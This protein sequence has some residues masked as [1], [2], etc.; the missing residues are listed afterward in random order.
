GKIYSCL[1]TYPYGSPRRVVSP[2]LSPTQTSLR[3][4]YI[5]T[6]LGTSLTLKEAS[7][8][9]ERAGYGVRRAT[10][11]T[12]QLEIPGYRT[13]IMHSVDII[14]VIALAMDIN[15]LKPEWLR[16]WTGRNFARGTDETES[17]ADIIDG[18]G[19]HVDL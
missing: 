3:L 4:S 2:D 17:V 10:G 11:D 18:L 5:N 12:I 19:V 16:I 6:L 1:E 14:E 13:D 15:E 8:F 9:A 7:R